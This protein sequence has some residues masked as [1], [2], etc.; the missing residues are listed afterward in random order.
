V[1]SVRYQPGNFSG[2]GGGGFVWTKFLARSAG[3][4]SAYFIGIG[5]NAGRALCWLKV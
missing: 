1:R 4:R 3:N 5:S 2:T